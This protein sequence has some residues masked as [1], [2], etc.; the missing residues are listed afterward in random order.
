[1]KARETATQCGRGSASV[2]SRRANLLVVAALGAA[3]WST[4]S[5]LIGQTNVSLG[6]ALDATNL[7]WVNS[8]WGPWRAQTNV[9]HDGVDAAESGPLRSGIVGQA[10]WLETSVQGPGMVSFWWKSAATSDQSTNA[11]FS[12]TFSAR[13][14]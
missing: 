1:M 10:A 7:V 3:L 6:E 13:G 5:P 12:Y 14:V 9:T 2:V 4:T 11:D 8:Y